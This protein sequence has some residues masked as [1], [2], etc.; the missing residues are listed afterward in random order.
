MKSNQTL[1]PNPRPLLQL[2]PTGSRRRA[3]PT[4]SRCRRRI[5]SPRRPHPLPSPR[6]PTGSHR[7]HRIQSPRRPHWLPSPRRAHWLPR[8]R[9]IP[10]PRR[11]HWLPSPPL[12]AHPLPSLDGADAASASVVAA[13][14]RPMARAHPLQWRRATGM[15]C[16]AVYYSRGIVAYSY[17]EY[18]EEPVMFQENVATM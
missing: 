9:W 15:A 16:R 5:P 2:A 18:F 1:P 17:E 7:R 4:G 6:R 14:E 10:S 11:P 3:T 13:P 8:R 12:E